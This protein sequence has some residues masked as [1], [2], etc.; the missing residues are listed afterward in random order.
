MLITQFH[1]PIREVDKVLP[2]IVLWSRERNLDERPP[3]WP[4]WF[5]D[6]THVRFARKPV[7]L[8]RVAPDA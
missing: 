5:A 4:F 2:E 3:F 8:A 7:A 6:Q 1:I